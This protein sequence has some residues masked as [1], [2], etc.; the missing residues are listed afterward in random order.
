[1]PLYSLDLTWKIKVGPLYSSMRTRTLETCLLDPFLAPESESHV[2]EFCTFDFG[3]TFGEKTFG[4]ILCRINCG[5]DSHIFSKRHTPN[6]L[7]K[8]IP[9]VD[10]ARQLTALGKSTFA[11]KQN[12][13]HS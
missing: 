8:V 4:Y 11:A 12:L 1:M 9:R 7:W 5:M 13:C 10:A 3:G 2:E 6:I